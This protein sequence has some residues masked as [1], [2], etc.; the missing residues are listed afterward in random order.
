MLKKITFCLFSFALLLGSGNALFAQ[1]APEF[2]AA[3]KVGAAI[4]LPGDTKLNLQ[5]AADL[6]PEEL[7]V[8]LEKTS[9]S[10]ASEQKSATGC[11]ACTAANCTGT[12]FAIPCGLYINANQQVPPVA[13]FLSFVTGCGTT[14]VSTCNDING[15]APCQAFALPSSSWGNNSC[16]NSS[17]LLQSVGCI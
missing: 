1:K 9:C 15:V 13:G 17:L 3:P 14:Y 12:C 2:T 7:R 16:I 6:T 5:N 8:A 4:Q 10:T 11:F